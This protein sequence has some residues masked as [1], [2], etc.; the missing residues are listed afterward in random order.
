M[1]KYTTGKWT[2]K[3]AR[4]N[5]KDPM[6]YK[7]DVISGGIRIAQVAGVGEENSNANANL[8]SAAPELLTACKEAKQWLEKELSAKGSPAWCKL[9]NAITKAEK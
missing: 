4:L 8:I 9:N 5:P 6:F 1:G 7:A 2:A 3:P